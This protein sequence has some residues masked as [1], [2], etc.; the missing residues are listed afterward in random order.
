MTKLW[1]GR[2]TKGTAKAVDAYTA[3]IPFDQR[4][5]AEDIA[6]SIAHARM[7]ARQGIITD[8]EARTLVD[9]LEA[10]RADIERGILTFT[11]EHE[12]IHTNVEVA[13]RER[14]GEVAGKLHTARSR[15]DQIALDMRLYLKR[16]IAEII[17]LLVNLQAALLDIA[18]RHEHVIMPGYTHTQRAQP[19]LFAHHMLAYFEM[20]QRDKGRFADCC[21]RADVCPLGSGALAGSTFSL[22]RAFVARELGFSAVSRNSLDAVSDRDF[23]LEFLAAA[24]ILMMHLSRLSEELIL[25]STAEF[26]FVTMDDAYATGSSMMP[27]KK[28]AAVAELTRGKTGRVYGHLLGLL[29][30]MKALPLSYNQDLQEDKEGLFDTVDTLMAA[31]P[32]LT[33]MVGSL[34]VNEDTMARAAAGSFMTATDL[35]DH[36]ARRGVPFRRAHQVVG[37]I[38]RHC[39]DNGKELTDLTVAEMQAFSPVFDQEALTV[40]RSANAVSARDVYGGTAPQQVRARLEEAR[41]VLNATPKARGR[42]RRARHPAPA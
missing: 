25:W 10:V 30:T 28:N 27:Q 23:V 5:Y 37:R 4:L 19:V 20:L 9:G 15:N 7:L 33:G 41:Q 6:G 1:G 16:I 12:D 32:L 42:S 2:F 26:G 24:S 40:V 36:L 14:V 21:K 8:E 17:D 39:L 35:A 34:V 3:S 11:A 31:L 22:D 13:L 18:E 38:V 29:T